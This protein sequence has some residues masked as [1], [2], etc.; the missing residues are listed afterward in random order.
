MALCE[1]WIG[2]EA[3]CAAEEGW[4]PCAAAGAASQLEAVEQVA[5]PK[6]VWEEEA[7]AEVAAVR[8]RH[9]AVRAAEVLA[10]GWA[11]AAAM[12]SVC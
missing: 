12:P 4:E 1:R 9:P 2:E 3:A 7:Y 6:E 5:S 10:A 11:E 8:P